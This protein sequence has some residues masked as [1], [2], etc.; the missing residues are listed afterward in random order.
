[1]HDLKMR[2]G[3]VDGFVFDDDDDSLW[4]RD[5][6][7]VYQA[8]GRWIVSTSVPLVTGLII[9]TYR[10]ADDGFFEEL[11]SCSSE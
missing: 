11:N 9:Y 10:K 3:P 4:G 6:L 5:Q 2:D 7:Y 1:M 8:N